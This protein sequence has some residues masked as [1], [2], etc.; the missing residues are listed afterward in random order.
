VND[1]AQEIEAWH[2]FF[3]L[4]GTMAATLMG[5]LFVSL[6]IRVDVRTQAETGLLRVTAGNNFGSY[7]SVMLFS[8]FFLIPDQDANALAT[9]I[10]FT[11]LFP[12]YLVVR[13]YLRMRHHPE[14]TRIGEF[15]RF[16]VPIA[17]Y[18]LGI[19][20]AIALYFNDDTEVY[21]FVTIVALLLVVPTRNAWAM[22]SDAPGEIT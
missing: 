10:F 6:S 20:V 4:S 3:I 16:I 12:L 14:L 1:F 13:G 17:C 11:S 15:W 8:L 2:D 18:L 21:W 7:L 9:E 5:L 22:I 19:F